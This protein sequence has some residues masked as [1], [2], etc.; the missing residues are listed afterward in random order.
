MTCTLVWFTVL[1]LLPGCTKVDSTDLKDDVPYHQSY[2]IIYSKTDNTTYVSAYFRVRE[3]GGARVKLADGSSIS[4]NGIKGSTSNPF[5]PTLYSWQFTGIR[6]VTTTLNKNGRILTNQV[7]TSDIGHV[8]FPVTLATEL[9]KSAD[10][11]FNWVGERLVAGEHLYLGVSGR[12]IADTTL[13]ASTERE[14]T[15]SAANI[16]TADLQNIVPGTL[17]VTLRRDKGLA[18]DAN[19]GTASGGVSV[20]ESVSKELIL[21]N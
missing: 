17:T 4:V 1:F 19:D 13:N 2:T 15:G 14:V 3:A 7:F 11:S 6:D 8:A 9:S 21:K 12:S 10:Y 16:T 18:L 5:D 20:T